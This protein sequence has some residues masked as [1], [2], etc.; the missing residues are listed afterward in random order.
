M[1]FSDEHLFQLKAHLEKT[2]EQA[3]LM[4]SEKEK[5][6]FESVVAALQSEVDRS[7]PLGYNQIL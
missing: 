5:T 7:G 2:A 1:S 6:S 4:L 3:V